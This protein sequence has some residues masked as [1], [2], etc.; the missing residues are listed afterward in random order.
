M[1]SKRLP[2]SMFSG[3]GPP[4]PLPTPNKLI[5]SSKIFFS[6]K[7][8]CAG[9]KNSVSNSLLYVFSG[10]KWVNTSLPSIPF[11]MKV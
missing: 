1:F 6:L 11:Q 10:G 7:F 8:V 4:P 3:L 5:N 9:I 2:S